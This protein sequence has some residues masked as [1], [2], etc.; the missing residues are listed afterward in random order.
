MAYDYPQATSGGQ[1][2]TGFKSYLY[3]DDPIATRIPNK[4]IPQQIGQM[5]QLAQTLYRLHNGYQ[6][7]SIEPER[8]AEYRNLQQQIIPELANRY[9]GAVG[10]EVV[11]AIQAR[12]RSESHRRCPCNRIGDLDAAAGAAGREVA[13]R[14]QGAA[15]P[16]RRP[17]APTAH[18]PAPKVR[19]AARRPDTCRWRPPDTSQR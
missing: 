18:K 9:G 17:H 8:Q 4:N 13:L 5:G 12:V 14:L 3:P 1:P 16:C 19:S 11:V 10:V 15:N 7:G 6:A 2:N